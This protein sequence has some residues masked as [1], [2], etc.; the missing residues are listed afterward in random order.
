MFSIEFSVEYGNFNSGGVPNF[1][2]PP[3]N[4]PNGSGGYQQPQGYP[5]QGNNW[6]PP[7]NS[8]YGSDGGYGGPGGNRDKFQGSGARPNSG[9]FGG[10][11]RM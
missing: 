1:S 4:F 6:G 9:N 5:A 11:K 3:P 8:S 10:A 2:V 7:Q